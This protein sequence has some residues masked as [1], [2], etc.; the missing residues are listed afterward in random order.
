MT[1]PLSSTSPRPA[2]TAPT[3]THRLRLGPGRTFVQAAELVPDLAATGISHLHL[4]NVLTCRPG[5]Q[6][7]V[8]TADHARVDPTLGGEEGLREL[9]RTAAREG[10][11]LLADLHA[12]HLQVGPWAPVW[13]QLLAEGRSSQVARHL[14]I[15]WET[16]LPGAQDKVILPVL[17]DPYGDVLA[18]GGLAVRHEE[19]Q[20]RVCYGGLTFPLN[21]ESV[22]ALERTGTEAL[23]G[24]PGRERTW[25]RMHNLLEQ[26]HYRLVSAAAGVRLVNYR[27]HGND[28]T[29]AALA[30]EDAQ[31]FDATHGLVGQ[32]VAD[33]VLQGLV[34]ADVEG[35]ADPRGYLQTLRE[36]V[37]PSTWLLVDTVTTPERG[38]PE[39]WPVEGTTGVET[40]RTTLGL[41]VDP[42]GMRQ[43]TALAARH[44]AVPGP[45]ERW[46]MKAD[47]LDVE[48]GPDLRL[49]T[50]RIWTACQDEPAVRDVDYRTLLEAVS[51]LATA[52]PVD[53]THLDLDSGEAS[54]AD[55]DVVAEM[56]DLARSDGGRGEV[57][58]RLWRYLHDLLTGRVRWTGTTADAVASFQQLTPAALR[59]G[60]HDRLFNRHH[61]LVAACD[62][63]LDPDD[64]TRTLSRARAELAATPALGLRTTATDRS[65]LGEDARLRIAALT[66]FA[67]EWDAAAEALLAQ[68]APPDAPLALRV[69]QV[70]VGAWPSADDGQSDPGQLL[71]SRLVA[72][73]RAHAVASARGQALHT[74][75][76]RPDEAFEQRLADWVG[77]LLDPAGPAVPTLR[78]LARRAAEI[79]MAAALSQVLVRS[80]AP[81]VPEL[82]EGTERWD[83]RVVPADGPDEDVAAVLADP[84]AAPAGELW[85]TRRDGRVK[86]HVIATALRLRSD[87]ADLLSAGTLDAVEVSGR[88]AEHVLAMRR[89]G[90]DRAD[91][92]VVAPRAFGRITDGGRFDP[93]GRIWA[94][95]DLQLPGQAPW[96][97]LL[98]GDTHPTGRVP[99][100]Q[101][102][103][104]L[105]VAL[106]LATPE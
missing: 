79:G 22:Q 66:G 103:A 31:V 90:A 29:L 65:V 81:G 99:A 49:C 18:A 68:T 46:R 8:G 69:L 89:S 97:D 23:A 34:V 50:R 6:R 54:D 47:V 42:A 91:L 53:R 106:L 37:G 64:V 10:I 35:L 12:H 27:R 86:Q 93:R 38:L 104:T 4:P 1:T 48:L 56:V 58:D 3:A 67:G 84:P 28:D 73:V 21:T 39:D 96:T 105:P 19:G 5:D 88:W 26:Q 16:P 95:T 51:R 75:H 87:H 63:G 45:R 13:E 44:D 41:Q 15:D 9:A 60:V 101:V 33:G 72:Q 74:S 52:L 14:H 102:L 55:E 30:V 76:R 61:A 62:T 85:R 40:L 36:L 20:P 32:L 94:D 17:D 77:V 92:V 80:T 25:Q 57:P 24:E 82:A 100:S 78:P 7:R 70:V 2:S 43:L 98:S 59:L 71:G 11:G 83:T